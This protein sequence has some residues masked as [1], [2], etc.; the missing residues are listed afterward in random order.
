MLKK[1]KKTSTLIVMKC[2]KFLS[3]DNNILLRSCADK[4]IYKHFCL[5][6]ANNDTSKLIKLYKKTYI[7]FIKII[8]N[9]DD[10]YIITTKTNNNFVDELHHD[11]NTSLFYTN[12][13]RF[14][15]FV[16]SVY[17]H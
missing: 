2:D 5:S 1:K 6:D 17:N 10:V 4:L 8:D 11:Y 12:E 9:I 13:K 7:Q 16:L 14:S 3:I 15:N